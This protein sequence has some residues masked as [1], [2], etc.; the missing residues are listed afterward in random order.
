MTNSVTRDCVRHLSA[1]LAKAL[2]S[3]GFRRQA[4]HLWRERDG[5]INVVHFQVSQWGSAQAGRFTINL[6]ST[7][8]TLYATWIGR[9]FPANPGTAIW[10]VQTR[11]GALAGTLDLWWDVDASTDADALCDRI[12]DSF[13]PGIVQWFDRYP[14]LGALESAL[15]DF[16]RYGDVPGVHEAQVPL[17]RAILKQQSG[18]R[19]AAA[20]LLADSMATSRGTP[21]AETVSIIASRLK[22]DIA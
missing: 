2:K 15:S 16:R 10:P 9:A 5:L 18:D 8:R 1:R 13:R 22:L 17:I 20:Q 21:F 11:I 19:V 14:S 6:A 4:P 7:N 3:E 12:V